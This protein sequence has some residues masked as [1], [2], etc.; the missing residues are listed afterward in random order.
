[1][2]GEQNKM[3]PIKWT[4]FL[5][6]VRVSYSRDRNLQKDTLDEYIPHISV[7]NDMVLV[8][9]QKAYH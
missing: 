5:A 6:L 2:G 4:P 7:S 9:L 8:L 1:M 3:H